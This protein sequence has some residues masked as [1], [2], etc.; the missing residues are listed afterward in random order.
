M[1]TSGVPW[2]DWQCVCVCVCLCVIGKATGHSGHWHHVQQHHLTEQ[3]S[4]ALTVGWLMSSSSEQ[5]WALCQMLLLP[6]S[7]PLLIRSTIIVISKWPQ[8]TVCQPCQW[9]QSLFFTFFTAQYQRLPVGHSTGHWSELYTKTF[10]SFFFSFFHFHA[11]IITGQW[12]LV[13]ETAAMSI[14]IFRWQSTLDNFSN[15]VFANFFKLTTL[16]NEQILLKMFVQQFITNAINF[17]KMSRLSAM[18]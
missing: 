4:S 5:Q 15:Q 1:P 6:S 14:I 2:C 11:L 12:S 9:Q 10:F 13:N 3:L 7:P 17:L 16:L 18:M 8:K